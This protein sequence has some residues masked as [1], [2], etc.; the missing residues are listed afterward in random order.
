MFKF[1]KIFL[2]AS[3]CSLAAIAGAQIGGTSERLDSE[4]RNWQCTGKASDGCVF[5]P[6]RTIQACFNVPS[7]TCNEEINVWMQCEG[8]NVELRRPCTWIYPRCLNPAP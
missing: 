6:T 3:I 1:V 7:N 5:L 8:F 4:C 2:F